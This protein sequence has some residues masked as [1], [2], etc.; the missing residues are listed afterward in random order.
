MHVKE[1]TRKTSIN[2]KASNTTGSSNQLEK[3]IYIE[4]SK[5]QKTRQ[6]VEAGLYITFFF[7]VSFSSFCW[8]REKRKKGKNRFITKVKEDVELCRGE[9]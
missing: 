5:A 7:V 2:R 1:T 8:K 9:G 3:K 4:T 6:N